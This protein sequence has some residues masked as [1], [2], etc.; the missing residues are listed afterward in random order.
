MI[1]L[2]VYINVPKLPIY[3]AVLNFFSNIIIVLFVYT[4][5]INNSDICI[6]TENTIESWVQWRIMIAIIEKTIL[7][8]V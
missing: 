3:N 4:N 5:I 7:S 1:F 6:H 2:L 8:E